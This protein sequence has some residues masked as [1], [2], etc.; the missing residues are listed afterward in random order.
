MA[1]YRCR[2]NPML[3][4]PIVTLPAPIARHLCA[5]L[6]SRP[7]PLGQRLAALLA[8]QIFP[9][10]IRHTVTLPPQALEVLLGVLLE[11]SIDFADDL[12]AEACGFTEA[13]IHDVIDLHLHHY[14]PL[15]DW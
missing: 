3:A 13:D 2:P 15:W 8:D 11:I 1:P 9:G 14:G 4:A 7:E 10:D 5:D 6:L 12:S